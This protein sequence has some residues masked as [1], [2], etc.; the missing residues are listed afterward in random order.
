M[1]SVDQL[2]PCPDSGPRLSVIDNFLSKDYNHGH[3]ASVCQRAKDLIDEKFGRLASGGPKINAKVTCRAKEETSLSEKLKM[4]NPTKKYKTSDD[5]LTDIADLAGVRIILY[6]P[7]DEQRRRVKETIE[8]IWSDVRLVQ[9]KGTNPMSAVDCVV[10]AEPKLLPKPTILNN[11]ALTGSL[12]DAENMRIGMKG[13]K[14][15]DEY[16][17]KHLGYEADHYRATME[18]EHAG[19]TKEGMYKWTKTDKVEIQVMSALLHAWAEAGHDAWYKQEAFGTPSREEQRIL[20]SL[21][22]LISSGDLLLDLY[23]ESVNKRTYARILH[24]DQLETFLRSVDILQVNN[25][26]DDAD[27]EQKMERRTSR[28]QTD[29]K[30]ES[31]DILLN[32]LAKRNKNYPFAVREALKELGYP[33]DPSTTFSGIVK[34]FNPAFVPPKGLLAPF[35]LIFQMLGKATTLE[36]PTNIDSLSSQCLIMINA[37]VLLQTFAGKVGTAIDILEASL[38]MTEEIEDGLQSKGKVGLKFVLQDPQ[39]WNFLME[40]REDNITDRHREQVQS[41]WNWFVYQATQPKSACGM[42]FRVAKIG[43]AQDD[44][45]E[46]SVGRLR[47]ELA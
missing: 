29:F 15:V 43:V 37:L 35:C 47:I 44:I 24:R 21:R 45:I 18:Q 26:E 27:T 11:E 13:K 31:V 17:P 14:P 16:V 5:I 25:Y 2:K 12:G 32:F 46:S 38:G 34:T 8:S 28:F 7:N 22:G 19:L 23:T 6:T 42:L 4:R 30:S 3:Y 40:G 36:Q 33:E 1:G 20:D 9:H 41:A 39:R 10:E